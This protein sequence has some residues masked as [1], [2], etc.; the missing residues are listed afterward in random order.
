M[1]GP[2]AAPG[3]FVAGRRIPPVR[4][5][6]KALWFLFLLAF[7]GQSAAA[8]TEDAGS[9]IVLGMSAP[10]SGSTADL[11]RNMMQ[12]MQV[13]FDRTNRSGGVH[14]RRLRLVALDDGYEPDRTVPNMRQ[15]IEKENVL[16]IV[17]NVGTPT[18]IAAVPISIGEKTLF[19]AGFTGSD[20]LRKDP[21][22]RYVI[23][24]RASYTEEVTAM[25]DALIDKG[26]LR[27]EDI[28]F[29]TQA[30]GYGDS[31]FK[32]VM[33][34]LRR[35][36]LT[37]DNAVLRVKYKRN[38]LAV[39]DAVASVLLATRTPRAVVMVGAYAP[40]AK[41]I[42]LSRESGINPLF[43][44]V[45]FVG[46]SSLAAALGK[47]D[48]Q[49]IVTQVVPHPSNTALPLIAEYQ[50]DLRASDPSAVPTFTSL[51]G[52]IAARMLAMALGRIDGPPT[53]ENIVD[54][55]ETLGR[56]DL[57]IGEALRLDAGD[58]QAC[59]RVWPTLMKGR[60]FM[61]YQWGELPALIDQKGA[62]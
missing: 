20:A 44:G 40:C 39:E 45:S 9:E 13:G 32:D 3:R 37:D 24:Y 43:L 27:P 4:P 10:L 8:A 30:D 48:A 23:N 19:F 55:L 25:I 1:R 58:H 61:P 11:G 14:G 12:G 50:A 18:A 26:G 47:T 57:G 41:F 52:Y 21:P 17:G 62:E 31:G 35:H 46:S 36:G 51:E 16:A 6:A 22:D 34:N 59:H 2:T 42:R 15:L 33:T 56:F 53:R 54:A 49:V 5:I 38:T 28:A 60:Q 29:F 7:L